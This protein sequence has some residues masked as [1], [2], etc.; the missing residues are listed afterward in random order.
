[1]TFTTGGQLGGKL[2]LHAGPAIAVALNER[3]DYF[4]TTVNTASCLEE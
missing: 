4:G 3:L 1:V 2:E